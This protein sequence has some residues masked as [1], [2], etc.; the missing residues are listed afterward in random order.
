MKTKTEE[1]VLWKFIEELLNSGLDYEE[2]LQET[3]NKFTDLNHQQA[4]ATIQSICHDYADG[5]PDAIP[6]HQAAANLEA[7]AS[8]LQLEGDFKAQPLEPEQNNE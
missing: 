2:I 1:S 6:S 4:L 8:N 5:A 7:W 3:R